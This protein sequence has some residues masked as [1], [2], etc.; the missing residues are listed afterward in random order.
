M[1]ALMNVS[2]LGLEN[3]YFSTSQIDPKNKLS[4]D[5]NGRSICAILD[6]AVWLNELHLLRSPNL[7]QL[8]HNKSLILHTTG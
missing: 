8:E 6:Y 2:G 4:F 1:D 7:I 5:F 3:G